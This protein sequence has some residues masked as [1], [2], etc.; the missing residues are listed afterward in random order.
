MINNLDIIGMDGISK[1]E[2]IRIMT[3]CQLE[4]TRDGEVRLAMKK[5]M[6][7]EEY[8]E[9]IDL[10]GLMTTNFAEDLHLERY[11]KYEQAVDNILISNHIEINKGSPT[12][13]LFCQEY[14]EA[15]IRFLESMNR[16]WVMDKTVVDDL[17]KLEEST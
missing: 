8:E 9:V 6:S 7:I 4:W 12:Y 11:S 13:R 15:S 3:Q 14:L 5:P 1:H 17:E 10:Y 2:I 16:L